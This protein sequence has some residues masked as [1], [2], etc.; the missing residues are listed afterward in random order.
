ME[1]KTTYDEFLTEYF[2]PKTGINIP[3]G[4]ESFQYIAEGLCHELQLDLI[5]DR[6]DREAIYE[7]Y[8]K[9]M[10]C[11]SEIAGKKSKIDSMKYYDEH[12]YD[13]FDT[14]TRK[15]FKDLPILIVS[16]TQQCDFY[17]TILAP[18]REMITGWKRTKSEYKTFFIFLLSR[19]HREY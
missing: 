4:D 12:K 13:L 19:L 16:E 10:K 5:D 3:L 18:R 15:G 14:L 1:L 6:H 7:I 8:G 11:M 9:V 2:I 17:M